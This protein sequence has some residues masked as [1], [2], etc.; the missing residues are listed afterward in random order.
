MGKKSREL[1]KPTMVLTNSESL[2][3]NINNIWQYHLLTS[4]LIYV[5]IAA[6]LTVCPDFESLV[7]L[8]SN[9]T[10]VPC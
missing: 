10:T 8:C 1:C 3:V 7:T 4:T 9:N 6:R 5:V 2:T